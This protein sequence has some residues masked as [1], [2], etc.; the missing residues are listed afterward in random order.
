M[1]WRPAVT[2]LLAALAILALAAATPSRAG[3]TNGESYLALDDRERDLFVQ[4]LWDMMEYL[5]ESIRDIVDDAGVRHIDRLMRCTE[6][7]SS[8]RLR[9]LLDAHYEAHPEDI[10]FGA[11]S[12][13]EAALIERCP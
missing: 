12:T 10:F 5:F 9:D 1:R 6:P 11:A 13:F 3:Y 7:L 2:P 4:A 8:D